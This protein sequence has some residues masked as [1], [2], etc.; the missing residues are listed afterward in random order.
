[1]RI[2]EGS[3]SEAERKIK[4]A[5]VKAT[6]RGVLTWVNENVGTQIRQGDPL[7]RVADLSS[8]KVQASI[9][10][11]Y[12]D[13]LRTGGPVTVRV[14]DTDL[15]GTISGIRPTVENGLVTFFVALQDRSHQLLRSNLRVDVFVVTAF[16]ENVVRVKNGPFYNG[17]RDQPVFVIQGDKAVRRKVNIGASNFDFVELK[18]QVQPGEEVIISDMSDY[19]NVEELTLK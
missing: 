9:S 10:D 14:N 2:Q 5:D 8:F 4:Q 17:S 16:V 18:D 3:L 19:K 15:R 7:A 13:Q 6:Q 12:A 11:T 1:M